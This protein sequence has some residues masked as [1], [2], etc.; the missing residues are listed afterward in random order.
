MPKNTCQSC[1]RTVMLVEIGGEM[2]ATDPELINVVP[3]THV[4]GDGSGGIRMSTRTTPARRIH[5]ERCEDYQN[6]TRRDRIAADLR[7]YNDKNGRP[8]RAPR[9]NHGL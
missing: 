4:Q 3:A 6:Q 9:K 1:N 8:P 5:A 7:A 2:V